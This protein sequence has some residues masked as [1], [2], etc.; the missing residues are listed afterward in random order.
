M[1]T[2][3]LKLRVISIYGLPTIVHFYLMLIQLS[4]LLLSDEIVC[5]QNGDII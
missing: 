3:E 2:K 1:R 5:Y 4:A